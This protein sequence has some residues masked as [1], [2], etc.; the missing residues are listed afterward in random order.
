M[1][2]QAGVCKGELFA[3]MFAN[4]IQNKTALTAKGD[5]TKNAKDNKIISIASKMTIV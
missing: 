1:L 4:V 2:A 3:L 5:E